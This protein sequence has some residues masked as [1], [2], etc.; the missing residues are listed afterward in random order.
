MRKKQIK[1][2]THVAILAA[3]SV[4][5]YMFL[6]FP[7]PFFPSFLDVQF[8]NLPVIIA[9]FVFGPIEACVVVLI[10]FII[11]IPFS[12][13]AMVGEIADLVI[14]CLVGITVSL[15]YKKFHTRKGGI[16]A[17]ISGVIVWVVA[18]IIANAVFLL[19]MY[20]E[21]YNLDAVLGLLSVI[22]GINA[23]NYLLYYIAFA[24][25]PFNLLL[26]VIVSFITFFV[27]KRVSFLYKEQIDERMKESVSN[28]GIV[29]GSTIIAFD[30][31]ILM[32]TLLWKKSTFEVSKNNT[33]LDIAITILGYVVIFGLGCYL[34]I[35]NI[36][37]NKKNKTI[38]I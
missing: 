5:L 29:I 14:G 10:R 17:L 37:K 20:I 4:I 34:I 15:V 6:K 31:L 7:L 35:R 2:M 24:V 9:G 25:I 33:K 16:M 28:E 13:T 3:L 26:A 30:L 22:K 8:S 32:G 27:Y 38:K 18:A 21:L 36:L 19:P 23:D 11:K 12:S 1:K